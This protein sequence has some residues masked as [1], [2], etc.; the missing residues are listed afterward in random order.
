MTSARGRRNEPGSARRS[1]VASGRD[2]E[3][4]TS[5]IARPCGAAEWGRSVEGRISQ[6]AR[7]RAMR[8]AIA[9][10]APPGTTHGNR[11]T[12]LRYAALLRALGHTV[13]IVETWTRGDHDLLVALHAGK[14]HGSIRAFRRAHPARPVVLVLTG[15]DVYGGLDATARASLEAAT[16]IVTLQPEALREL[17][18]ASRAKATSILQAAEAVPRKA[19]GKRASFRVVSLGHLRAVKDPFVLADA[20]ALLDS[21]SKIAAIHA[22]EALDE[23]HRREARRRSVRGSRWKWT[24]PCRHGCA[25][26]LLASADLFVQTSI[27][28]GGSVALAEAIV[29][30]APVLVTRIPAAIGMLGGRHPGFF[31]VGDARELARLMTRVEMDAKF[32]ARL[33]RESRRLAPRFAP[34]R[35]SAAWR[36]LLA[37]L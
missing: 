30:G 16:R 19:R 18:R 29:T 4:L 8:I 9:T 1:C 15:T 33:E 20:C 27:A 21:T 5:S 23:A 3:P 10:P 36:R 7:G 2:A 11:R 12:A 24:G 6:S 34:E 14:S 31:A 35:E 32:R 28:E 26:K 17:D 13:R 37:G 25:L 22:G